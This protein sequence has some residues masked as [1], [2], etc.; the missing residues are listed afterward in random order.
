MEMTRVVAIK[1]Y[2]EQDGPGSIKGRKVENREI[3]SLTKEDRI[4]LGDACLKALGAT[5]KEV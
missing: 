3:M 5:L 2:L 4:E 1:T